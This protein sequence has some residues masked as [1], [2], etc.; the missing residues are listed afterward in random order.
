MYYSKDWTDSS[1]G[2]YFEKGFYDE[3]GKHYK[4]VTIKDARNKKILFRCEY[5]G[6]EVKAE[7]ESGEKP[8]CPNCSAQLQEVATDELAVTSP[9]DQ[10]DYTPDPGAYDSMGSF[11]WLVKMLFVVVAVIIGLVGLNSASDDFD[12]P[13]SNVV[14]N[15]NPVSINTI[16]VPELGHSCMWWSTYESYYDQTTDCYFYYNKDIDYPDWQYWYEGISSDYGDYGW[17]EYELETDTWFIETDNG[18]W[19][20]LPEKYNKDNLWH[21]TVLPSEDN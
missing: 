15:T 10:F 6:T 20:E 12:N 11:G 1:T 4:N 17:M 2:K 9:F 13:R 19:I 5:C 18:V 8:S 16:Y 21:T 7:W 14:Y 3:T